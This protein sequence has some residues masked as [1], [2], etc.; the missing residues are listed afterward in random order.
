MTLEESDDIY[1][2]RCLARIPSSEALSSIHEIGLWGE[3][4]DANITLAERDT[5]GAG[6]GFQAHTSC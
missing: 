6:A 3:T 1:R 2:V 4:L 5:G